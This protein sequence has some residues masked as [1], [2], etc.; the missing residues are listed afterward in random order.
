MKSREMLLSWFKRGS[1]IRQK[2]RSE[3]ELQE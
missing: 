3:A 1:N 2:Q